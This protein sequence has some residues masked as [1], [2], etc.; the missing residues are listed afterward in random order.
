MQT[1]SANDLAAQLATL[2]Q[3]AET[4]I[5]RLNGNFVVLETPKTKTELINEKYPEL[6]GVGITLS[7]AAKKY[8][9]PRGALEKWVHRTKDVAFADETSYPKLIDESQVALLAELYHLRLKDG[10]TGVPYFDPEG[11][12]ITTRQHPWLSEYRKRKKSQK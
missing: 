1:I 9:V 8:G 12:P 3:G 10:L 6:I 5:V 2:P 4:T 7:Q 11:Y